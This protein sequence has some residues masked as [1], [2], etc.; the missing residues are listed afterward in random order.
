MGVSQ[1]FVSCRGLVPVDE[2]KNLAMWII[3]YLPYIEIKNWMEYIDKGLMRGRYGRHKIR[4]KATRRKI[5]KVYKFDGM[6]RDILE[7]TFEDILEKIPKANLVYIFDYNQLFKG[8]GLDAIHKL[9][10]YGTLPQVLKQTTPCPNLSRVW[11]TIPYDC[12]EYMLNKGIDPCYNEQ[13]AGAI[14]DD[15]PTP[16]DDT[17]TLNRDMVRLLLSY[18]VEPSCL[19]LSQAYPASDLNLD[20]FEYLLSLG[21]DLN[22]W[23]ECLTYGHIMCNVLMDRVYR[24]EN[25]INVPIFDP[26]AYI[27]AMLRYGLDLKIGLNWNGN[28]MYDSNLRY[29]SFIDFFNR[30]C[31]ENFRG[32]FKD[33]QYPEATKLYNKIVSLCTTTA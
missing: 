5:N 10:K 8:F 20:D 21:V 30:Y 9:Y 14:Y 28:D 26:I 24:C 3:K 6:E 17:L 31:E 33:N 23:H 7:Q 25:A 13:I 32:V 4:T 19:F 18:G 29:Q 12:M 27:D 11:D 1:L 15:G 22:A 16:Y 2:C